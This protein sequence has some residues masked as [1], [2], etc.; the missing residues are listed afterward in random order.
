MK[1]IE[2]LFEINPYS[3]KKEE[4]IIIFKKIINDL[5]NH[6]YFNS[7]DYRKLLNYFNYDEKKN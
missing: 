6:H 5:T 2:K 7:K 3:L 1:D 4:K